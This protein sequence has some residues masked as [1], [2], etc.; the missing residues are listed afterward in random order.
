[1]RGVF[2]LVLLAGIGLAGFAAKMVMDRLN[3]LRAERDWAISQI[4]PK[5]PM[6]EVF[7]TTRELRAG[8]A[9]T[10]EDVQPIAWPTA[11]L[12][13]NTYTDLTEIFPEGASGPRVI[14]RMMDPGELLMSP[15]LSQPGAPLGLAFQLETG[16]RAFAI[17]VDVSSGVSGFLTPGDRV[18]IYWTG[19]PPGSD[20]GRQFTRLI[21]SNVELVA[22]DQSRD[23]LGDEARVAKTITVSVTPQE[24]AALA[25]AQNS[26][27]L[28]LALV[29][30]ADENSQIS[31]IEVDTRELLGIQEVIEEEVEIEAAPVERICTVRNRRGAE[32]IVTEI[33]CTD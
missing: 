5:V 13:E 27:K 3:L 31:V 14:L 23:F 25:Q 18:D 10:R 22:I 7:V 1:M 11:S 2:A 28:S 20:G 6:S 8:E 26:G 30:A 33:P 21:Q 9:L 24:V 32:V 19:T 29:G 12:P 4:G 17:R 15:K 16:R